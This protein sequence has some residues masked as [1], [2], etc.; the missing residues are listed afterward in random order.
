MRR[1]QSPFRSNRFRVS[2]C[3]IAI[4]LMIAAVAQF[5]KAGSGNPEEPWRDRARSTGPR[6]VFGEGPTAELPAG[7][8]PAAPG[9]NEPQEDDSGIP[10]DVDA[11]SVVSGYPAMDNKLWLRSVAAFARLPEMV[12]ELRSLRKERTE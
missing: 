10:N 12:R 5:R 2:L 9:A 3:V 11:N 6:A 1:S 7:P 8:S 4:V